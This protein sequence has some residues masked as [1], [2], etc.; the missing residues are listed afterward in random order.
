[1]NTG[2]F[3]TGSGTDVGKTFIAKRLVKALS[4]H[5]VVSVRKP[6]E[7]DC[8]LEGGELLTKDAA[9]LQALS[10]A[11]E[12]IDQVCP[13]R[14]ALCAS[15]EL[16][17]KADDQTLDLAQLVA[18]S[19]APNFVLVEGAGGLYSPIAQQALNIDLAKALELPLIL[20]VKD[21]LG[22][23]NQALLTDTAA[24]SAG[25]RVLAIVLNQFEPNALANDQAIVQY[26]DTPVVLY[27]GDDAEFAKQMLGLIEQ[28]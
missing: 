22:A 1:M 4:E 17:A 19:Q 28:G 27:Q 25:L 13:Y 14:F 21:E 10:N 20:V 16:A 6:V 8:R 11:G 26:T 12:S 7:S 5:R 15:P 24:Q 2:I 23:I 3:I 9:A 18:A